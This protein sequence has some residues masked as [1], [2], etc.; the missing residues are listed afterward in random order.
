[1]KKWLIGILIIFMFLLS[2]C[3]TETT[4]DTE[5]KGKCLEYSTEYKFECGLFTCS[6][7]FCCERKYDVCVRWENVQQ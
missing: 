4:S 6:N 5:Q 2:G 7:S 3:D 1:M